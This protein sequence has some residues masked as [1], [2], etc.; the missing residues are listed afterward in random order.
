MKRRGPKYDGRGMIEAWPPD[1]P[2]QKPN[3]KPKDQSATETLSDEER[4][5]GMAALER[6]DTVHFEEAWGDETWRCYPAEVRQATIAI[7]S[8]AI[9]AGLP[10][11]E[12]T[13]Q[14]V[15]LYGGVSL[16]A[17]ASYIQDSNAAG[18]PVPSQRSS[19]AHQQP[20]SPPPQ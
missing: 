4:A 16:A 1:N 10:L 9:S 13:L 8:R 18:I 20:L 6:M 3:P 15:C 14:N 17:L 5:K 11:N 19:P 2:P 12:D 7:L